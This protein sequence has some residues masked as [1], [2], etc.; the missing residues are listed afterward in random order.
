M[1]GWAVS[2]TIMAG[3]ALPR[4]NKMAGEHKFSWLNK[5]V[6]VMKVIIIM[7]VAWGYLLWGQWEFYE[8]LFHGDVMFGHMVFAAIATLTGL[9]F[10]YVLA[11]LQGELRDPASIE[12]NNITVT[13]VSLA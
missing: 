2:L 5:G 1:F 4:L 3:V 10:L 11:Y 7:L 12:T 8:N 9:L 6:H 13:G